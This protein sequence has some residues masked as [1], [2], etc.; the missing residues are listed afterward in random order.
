MNANRPSDNQA[1]NTD[2]SGV[3]GG[4]AGGARVSVPEP[5]VAGR[6]V[7]EVGLVLVAV[8]PLCAHEHRYCLSY[9]A[10][11]ADPAT[12]RGSWRWLFSCPNGAGRYI[13]QVSARSAMM[14]AARLAQQVAAQHGLGVIYRLPL[15]GLV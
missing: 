15:D 11:R 12:K 2:D 6:V 4:M 13:L 10:G 1:D 14:P 8:C 3:T 5:I 9:V 7:V